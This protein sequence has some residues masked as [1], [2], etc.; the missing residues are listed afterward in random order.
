M[1]FF[2]FG[3]CTES[4]FYSINITVK[5]EPA[6]NKDDLLCELRRLLQLLTEEELQE[7]IKE[8]L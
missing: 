8:M 6:V 1:L 4:A 2:V 5:G 3:Y 7:L